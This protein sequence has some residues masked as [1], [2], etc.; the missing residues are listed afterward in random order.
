MW[1]VE[2]CNGNKKNKEIKNQETAMIHVAVNNI[3]IGVDIDGVYE[4]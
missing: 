1:T 3:H 2:G 4:G